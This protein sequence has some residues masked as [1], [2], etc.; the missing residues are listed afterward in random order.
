MVLVHV[1]ARFRRW[2]YLPLDGRPALEDGV[3]R[4]PWS[5]TEIDEAPDA[6]DRRWGDPAHVAQAFWRDSDD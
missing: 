2:R 6:E 3:L 5:R 1:G 4:V